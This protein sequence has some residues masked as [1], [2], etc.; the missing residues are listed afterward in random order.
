MDNLTFSDDI[1]ELAE[2]HS[3]F[4]GNV[5]DVGKAQQGYGY[6]YADLAQILAAAR[7]TLSAFGLSLTQFPSF[8]MYPVDQR[9]ELPADSKGFKP[10]VIGEVT[11]TTTLAH[12]SGQWMRGILQIPVETM[13]NLSVAQAVGAAISYGRRYHAA[14][15]LAIAQEDND[16]AR[17]REDGPQ[18][19]QQQRQPARQQRQPE[20]SKPVAVI[21]PKDAQDIR[22][23]VKAM[24]RNPDLF[25]KAVATVQKVEALPATALN[26]AHKMLEKAEKIH[27]AD[28]EKAAQDQA[29]E[30][31]QY[32]TAGDHVAADQPA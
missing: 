30:A 4:L 25:A 9:F 28:Q 2:A 13:K 17:P 32:E 12:G 10:A 11:I 14:A 26:A 20:K 16:A 29:A 3:E 8:S 24:G 1:S 5:S 7:P 27:F 18:Q 21:S 22:Q 31:P 19:G 6:K 23:R 15:I